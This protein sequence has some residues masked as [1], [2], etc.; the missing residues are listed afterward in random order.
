MGAERSDVFKFV[1]VRPVQLAGDEETKDGI[2]RDERVASRDGLAKL[3]ELARG[4]S[5][6]E[7]AHRHWRDLRVDSLAAAADGARKLTHWYEGLTAEATPTGAE[8]LSELGVEPPAAG[9]RDEA[10]EALY[11]AHATGPD[12]GTLLEIPIAALRLCHYAE[13]LEEDPSP[14]A[15]RASRRLRAQPAISPQLDEALR[16]RGKPPAPLAD[17][18][19]SAPSHSPMGARAQQLASELASTRSLLEELSRPVTTSPAELDGGKPEKD[20]SWSRQRIA[21]DT[22]PPLRAALGSGVTAA[23]AS[24]LDRVGVSQQTPVPVASMMLQDHVATL[25]NQALRFAGDHDFEVGLAEW[26]KSPV[27]IAPVPSEDPSTA[28]DVDVHGEIKPL[29]IGDLKVV[30]QQL[31]AYEA[32][33]VA[34]IENVLKGETKTR[35]YRTL[36]R[37]ETA[38][39]TSEEETKESER[40]TQATDRFE[41]KRETAQTIK[42]DM[43]IKAG[44]SVTA[45]YGPVVATASGDFAYSTAKEE[46]EK[47]SSDFARQVVD[48]SVSKIQTKVS[49]QRTLKTLNEVEETN[50]HSLDNKEG[51]EH[52]VGIYRWVDKRYRAQVYNY[53]KRMILEF[54]VPEPAAFYRAAHGGPKAK[55]DAT[56]PQPFL[57][58]LTPGQPKALA[59][60][61]APRD[62]D[63]NNYDLYASRYGATGISPPPPL[64]KSAGASLGKD[65]LD[66]GKSISMTS[67]DFVVPDG[68]TL[69]SYQL[70]ASVLWINYPKFTVQVAGDLYEILNNTSGGNSRLTVDQEG[71]ASGTVDGPVPVSVSGYDVHAYSLNVEGVCK[72]NP[73]T[74]A[75]WQLQTYDKIQAAYQALQTAYDQ[76][77][78]QAAAAAAETIPG[79]NP[80]L[81]RSVI[82]NELKKL[83]ITMMTGQHFGQFHAVTDP[84]DPPT[85]IPEVEVEEALREGPIVQFFEQAFEWEQMTYLFYPYFW[86]RKSK[87]AKTTSSV[88][89]PDP[90]FEQF[91]TAG[92]CRVVVPVPLAYVEAVLFLLQSPAT[93]LADK[94]WLG[95]ER[96]TLESGLYESLAEELRGQTDDLAGAKP[97]GEPWE[98]TL[99]TTLTWLQPDS[100]LPTFP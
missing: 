63:D 93:D 82:Q 12:A 94:V 86:G 16:T 80:A 40:D 32:G 2:V 81:N 99:P 6:P 44:L 13:L 90:S 64:Y 30:K 19:E 15:A 7:A 55:V 22:T 35:V 27:E 45:S 37:T 47:S 95:G 11:T 92:S 78:A 98:Y 85:H 65:G 58:D 50:T 51:H 29:G 9:L 21:V 5:T 28:A 8:V 43:S 69:Y 89:D 62:L 10:W 23:Q 61:L 77:V 76:K 71:T 75:A 24:I 4:I 74:Y 83:C 1:A 91:L 17:G 84:T 57:N 46:S 48:R 42:E 67:K 39:V 3:R 73:E 88:E 31:L 56:P 87:W 59:R 41:L 49:T 52:V 25:S 34:Y 53:G 70:A 66:D 26:I 18:S 20:G 79:H 97:E 100:A 96:P 68:Y 14:P 33:E 38:L 54:V 60:R 72:R 36:D